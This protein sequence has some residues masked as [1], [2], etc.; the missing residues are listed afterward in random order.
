MTYS[1]ANAA[2]YNHK[3]NSLQTEIE[4]AQSLINLVA[5][6]GLPSSIQ[7]VPHGESTTLIHH[8]QYGFISTFFQTYLRAK[9]AL[10]TLKASLTT[11]Q[12]KEAANASS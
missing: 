9:E 8:P 1:K 7:H 4:A 6:L 12:L 2:L 5:Y 11:Y 3:I 10:P